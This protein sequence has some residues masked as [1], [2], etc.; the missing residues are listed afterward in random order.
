MDGSRDGARGAG[1]GI[2]GKVGEDVSE[3][4][5]AVVNESLVAR[6]GS[7]LVMAAGAVGGDTSGKLTDA[8]KL[9]GGKDCWLPVSR[10][11]SWRVRGSKECV[12]S[13]RSALGP[14]GG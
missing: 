9:R 11:L 10:I 5:L 12:V 7:G 8:L 1:G 3:F 6:A 2:R 13:A 4:D 14:V